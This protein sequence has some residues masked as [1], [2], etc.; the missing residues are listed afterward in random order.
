M[1]L[2]SGRFPSSMSS[3]ANSRNIGVSYSASSIAGSDRLNHCCR[4]WTRS[5]VSTAKGGRPPLAPGVGACGAISDTSSAQGTTRFISSRNSRLRVLFV[6]RSNP[7]SPR[8]ICFMS[9]MSHITRAGPRLCRP[10]LNVMFHLLGPG[11][12]GASRRGPLGGLRRKHLQGRPHP[13]RPAGEVLGRQQPGARAGD[14]DQRLGVLDIEVRQHLFAIRFTDREFN[15]I[16]MLDGN[17]VLEGRQGAHRRGA[18]GQVRGNQHLVDARCEPVVRVY[19]IELEVL[20]E[21][22]VYVQHAHAGFGVEGAKVCWRLKVKEIFF[23][24]GGHESSC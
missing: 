2:S 22:G 14:L 13:P 4:K 1:V 3:P 8:L 11:K 5:M 15:G 16:Y 18:V 10:S 24:G 6:L 23:E 20:G 12:M 7:L 21:I 9:A 17:D 19:A